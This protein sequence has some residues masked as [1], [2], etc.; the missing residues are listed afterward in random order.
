MYNKKQSIARQGVK[1]ARRK[2]YR[3]LA[4]GIPSRSRCTQSASS[5]RRGTEAESVAGL[6][7]G[8]AAKTFMAPLQLQIRLMA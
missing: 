1:L 3:E 8:T 5:F 4:N 7:T 6:P 2:N